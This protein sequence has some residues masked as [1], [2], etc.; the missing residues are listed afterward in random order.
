MKKNMF[1]SR[2]S[3]ILTFIMFVTSFQL[4]AIDLTKRADALSFRKTFKDVELDKVWKIKFDKSLKPTIENI[5][6]VRVYDSNFNYIETIRD[7]SDNNRTIVV[8]PMKDYKP[9]SYYYIFIDRD[10]KAADGESFGTEYRIEFL[11]KGGV[12]TPDL[13]VVLDPGQTFAT[14]VEGFGI[15]GK[16]LNLDIA[17]RVGNELKSQGVNVIYT[18]QGD[19]VSWSRE[20]D[21]RKRADVAN[22]ANADY[23]VSIYCNL[24]ETKTSNGIETYYLE[25]KNKDEQF[26]QEIQD[27]VIKKTG[28]N[29]R[30]IKTKSNFELFEKL[31]MPGVIVEVGFLT[32]STDAS[33]LKKSSYKDNIAQGISKVILSKVKTSNSTKT[34]IKP[35]MKYMSKEI[36]T[37]TDFELP[38]TLKITYKNSGEKK[39]ISVNWKR[40][41]YN[42]NKSGT[43]Y[44][45]GTIDNNGTEVIIE[46]KLV[47]KGQ[48]NDTED[49]D[50]DNNSD[51]N[52]D[53]NKQTEEKN[54][55][56]TEKH[57][58]TLNAS[59]GGFDSGVIGDN[60]VIEKDLNLEIALKAGEILKT[61]GYDIVYTRESDYVT[62]NKS[63]EII[64]RVK[65]SD[66]AKS[67]L[68]INI[69]ANSVSNTEVSGV[70]TFYR[71]GNKAGQKA[72]KLI[73]D[74]VIQ[75]TGA[76]Y[77]GVKSN[78]VLNTLRLSKAPAIWV[79]VGFVSNE[80]EAQRLKETAYKNRIALGI[81][82]AVTEYFN[83]THVDVKDELH[84]KEITKRI[85]QGQ[86]FSLPD[87]IDII[88][89]G[90][91]EKAYKVKWDNTT[92][93]TSKA[94]VFKYEGTLVDREERVVLTLIIGRAQ[95][96][97]YKVVLDPGH[98]GYDSGA[99][100]YTKTREKD[101][102]LSVALMVGNYLVRNGVDVEYTRT[103]DKVSW[104]SNVSQDL[105]VRTNI[106]NNY[107]PDLFISIH[108]NSTYNE[109]AHGVETY[110]F[111]GSSQGYIL[112]S[113]IQNELIKYTGANNRG[114]KQKGF[115][116]IKYSDAPAALIEL[117]FL[118]N[119]DEEKRFKSIEEQ[120]KYARAISVGIFKKLGV[121]NYDVT[122]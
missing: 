117:G 37:G 107:K 105:K 120:K 79:A 73:Q 81:A 113:Y 24:S 62:W 31:K 90:M 10:L 92:V 118:S 57:V 47:V 94:G 100:G 52:T 71:E 13:T 54:D 68:M 2:I 29:D 34:E 27:S 60:G 119:K 5:N 49:K 87:K 70:E 91:G 35:S 38:E 78:T 98:G 9:G 39:V 89:D 30:G 74:N 59:R 101:V 64:E 65:I 45:Y 106:A 116:V 1:L 103:S 102:T 95:K 96:T 4:G 69:G 76:T 12:S 88:L 21:M 97:G 51:D 7:Y 25:G 23:M 115:Y 75:K 8:K 93:N 26:A 50:T 11:T 108:L 109:T 83:G 41:I 15:L 77:R 43:Y 63:N 72:A 3:L 6:K 111:Y 28:A 18:R 80:E 17:K 121:T 114:V 16:D 33:N 36:T 42:V 86:V 82:D 19:N 53:E 84:V 44:C 22:K 55:D 122:D 85:K 48:E 58:V 46:Y 14:Y 56:N 61:R 104:P 66:D 40:K 99:I 112:A 32:N 67:E 110:S 20:E